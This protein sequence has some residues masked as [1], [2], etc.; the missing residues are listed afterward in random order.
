MF[1]EAIFKL[2]HSRTDVKYKNKIRSRYA[3]LKDT[4]NPDLRASVMEGA[5]TPTGIFDQISVQL[6]RRFRATSNILD[7]MINNLLFQLLLQAECYAHAF[8]RQMNLSFIDKLGLYQMAT[9][10]R[11]VAIKFNWGQ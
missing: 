8:K 11:L 4:K 2:H 9:S 3:N 10:L 5:I 7:C 6:V 1:L